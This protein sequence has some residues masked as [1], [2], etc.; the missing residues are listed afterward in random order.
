MYAPVCCAKIVSAFFGPTGTALKFI[1]P[2]DVFY[3][4]RLQLSVKSCIKKEDRA[5]LFPAPSSVFHIMERAA[6]S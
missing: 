1:L 3:V 5:N 2:A 6:T 4:F